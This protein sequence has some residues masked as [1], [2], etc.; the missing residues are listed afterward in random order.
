MKL[1]ATHYQ[2]QLI[3]I[4]IDIFLFFLAYTVLYSQSGSSQFHHLDKAEA[5]TMHTS[6]LN[7]PG[8]NSPDPQHP[9]VRG[10]IFFVRQ[11]TF[12]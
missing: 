5:C 3:E 1:G 9:K 11:T 8:P 12:R 4:R 10:Q 2:H 7:S 6:S